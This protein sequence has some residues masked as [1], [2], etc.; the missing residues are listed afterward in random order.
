MADT[1]MTIGEKLEEARKRRGISIREAAEATKVRGDYLLAME[2]SSFEI[3][4]PEIYIRGFL[5]IYVNYL[6]LDLEKFMA[7]YDAM[8]STLR[9]GQRPHIAPAR[10]DPQPQPPAPNVV[11]SGTPAGRN[12]FGRMELA[13]SESGDSQQMTFAP[14]EV[15][16]GTGIPWLRPVLIG[17]AALV[18]AVVI[19]IVIYAVAGSPRKPE[20]NPELASSQSSAI[21]PITL[22]ASENVTVWVIRKSDG[23]RVFEGTLSA[24]EN[25]VV[26]VAGQVEVRFTNGRALMIERDGQ[27]QRIGIDGTGRTIFE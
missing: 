23:T 14:G 26:D 11:S 22:I 5:R 4:L 16:A 21:R 27:K 2:N 3:N 12:S 17:G 19:G 20:I 15:P 1:A 24:G 25:K 18:V 13:P 10:R 6:R 9:K 7:D 8:R